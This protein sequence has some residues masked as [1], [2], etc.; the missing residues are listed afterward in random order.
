WIGPAAPLCWAGY[1]SGAGG[2]K[3]GRAVRGVFK[4]GRGGAPSFCEYCE[5]CAYETTRKKPRNRLTLRSS[6]MG[7]RGDVWPGHRQDDG[8]VRTARHLF[9][10]RGLAALLPLAHILSD[11]LASPDKAR[12]D[13]VKSYI[14]FTNLDP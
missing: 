14:D 12:G 8:W 4:W 10:K 5:L 11:S 2:P 7:H 9:Q 13:L 3:P 6:R 1:S